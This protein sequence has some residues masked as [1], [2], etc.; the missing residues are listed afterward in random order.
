MLDAHRSRRPFGF[1]DDPAF[2]DALAGRLHERV[3]ARIRRELIVDRERSGLL[4]PRA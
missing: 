4:I 1:M 2:L 3:L